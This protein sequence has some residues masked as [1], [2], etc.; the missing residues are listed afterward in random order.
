MAVI[1]GMRFF[2]LNSSN[3][4]SSVNAG[5]SDNEFGVVVMAVFVF[6]F[7]SPDSTLF[8]SLCDLLSMAL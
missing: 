4:P 6:V 2:S 8:S 1:F 5:V 7:V 3:V